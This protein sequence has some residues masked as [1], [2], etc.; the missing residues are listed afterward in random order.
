MSKKERTKV[1]SYSQFSMYSNCPRQYKLKYIDKLSKKESS[2]HLIFGSSM[3]DTVQTYLTKMYE[4]S[5]KSADMLN[6]DAMLMKAL[7][8]NFKKEKEKSIDNLNPCTQLELEEFYG[9]GRQILKWFKSNTSKFYKKRGY[10]LVGIE[11]KLDNQL[12]EGLQFLGFI[13]VCIRNKEKDIYTIIDLKTSTWGWS[14]WE[15]ND[16]IKTS[17]MLLYKK[18]YA[19]KFDVSLDKITVEYQ[20]LKRK[21]KDTGW[22]NP[23]IS[24]FVPSHGTPSTNKAYKEFM[25]FVDD[26]FNDDG[27]YKDQPYRKTPGEKQRNCKF[28]EFLGVH[29]DGKVEQTPDF[30]K[31]T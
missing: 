4:S 20:I 13:D 31:W 12:K 6:L 23:R 1:V 21:L 16:K 7:V 25:N 26:V 29:C 3:H 8:D 11:L 28:C 5:K 10:E 15:K 22:S 24:R 2:I 9:Q 27:S 17:Q 18:F 14:H 19:G 30:N